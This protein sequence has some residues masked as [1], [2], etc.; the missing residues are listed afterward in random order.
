MDKHK[1]L[2]K[3]L[4]IILIVAAGVF[5]ADWAMGKYKFWQ[6]TKKVDK[7]AQAL[8]D[9]EK[10]DY[11]MAMADTFGGQTPQ[12]T[13][14]MFIKAVEQGD[15]EL[16]SKYFIIPKQTDELESLKSAPKENIEN[17]LGLLR[18]I[19]MEEGSYNTNGDNYLVR[20][21]ILVEFLLYPNGVWKIV[22]I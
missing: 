16:A 6:E 13:L 18:Q 20:K 14:E 1:L 2:K 10:K 4:I 15:Y 9:I 11:E 8:R 5:L 19:N 17:V 22:E 21:P 3:V 7:L 12:E